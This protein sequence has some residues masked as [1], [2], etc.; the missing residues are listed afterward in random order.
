MVQSFVTSF[1]RS[2]PSKCAALLHY[3]HLLLMT[4][5]PMQ[6][7]QWVVL[8]NILM[9]SVKFPSLIMKIPCRK[10]RIL[11]YWLN[12]QAF[13]PLISYTSFLVVR[14]IFSHQYSYL[15]YMK[16]FWIWRNSLSNI[17]WLENKRPLTYEIYDRMY[18]HLIWKIQMNI[19][20]PNQPFSFKRSESLRSRLISFMRHRIS[21]SKKSLINS[22]IIPNII[23]V[24]FMRQSFVGFE[25]CLSFVTSQ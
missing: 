25:L 10:P 19:I 9:K 15:F 12:F 8:H 11:V 18:L 22:N 2:C 21:I 7:S 6:V 3:S 14:S 17:N 13:Q 24:R 20:F 5:S 4:S 16:V 1:H 23:Q